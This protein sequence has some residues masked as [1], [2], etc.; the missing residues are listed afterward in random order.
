[1]RRTGVGEKFWGNGSG[2][3]LVIVTGHDDGGV[4]WDRRAPLPGHR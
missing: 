2:K 3:Y 1:V 4:A